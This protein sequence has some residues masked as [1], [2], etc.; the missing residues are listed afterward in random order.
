MLNAAVVT[1]I[2]FKFRRLQRM[3]AKLI[4]EGKLPNH[5]GRQLNRAAVKW[6]R[7]AYYKIAQVKAKAVAR[8]KKQG[9]KLYRPPS[10]KQNFREFVRGARQFHESHQYNPDEQPLYNR[11]SMPV[12]TEK[13]CQKRNDQRRKQS[14]KRKELAK[15]QAEAEG[16]E[17]K[18]YVNTPKPTAEPGAK[19][20]IAEENVEA[21][22]LQKAANKRYACQTT[23][24]KLRI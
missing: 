19:S 2:R 10:L 22:R 24:K 1:H 21:K 17:H 3:N 7:A 15:E 13:S 23:T 8:A 20:K 14:E 11:S 9:R 4:K 16:I 18:Q 6:R 12:K 5:T